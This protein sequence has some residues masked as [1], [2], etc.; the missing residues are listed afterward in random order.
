M[1]SIRSNKYL[2]EKVIILYSTF[3][4]RY[5]ITVKLRHFQYDYKLCTLQIIWSNLV[6]YTENEDI[7]RSR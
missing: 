1:Q 5:P 3:L 4:P 2:T 7:Y 6:R